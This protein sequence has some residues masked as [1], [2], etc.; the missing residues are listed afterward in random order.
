MDEKEY[1]TTKGI[2]SR[3]VLDLKTVF[4][5]SKTCSK[6]L[7]NKETE[8]M[9]RDLVIRALDVWDKIPKAAH[10]LWNDIIEAAG[11]YPY[12]KVDKLQGTALLRQE[13]HRSDFLKDKFLHSEQMGLSHILHNSEQSL[14]VSAPTSFGKSLLIEELVASKKYKNIVVIQPT[15]ALLDETRKKLQ[16]YSRE[17]NIVVATTQSFDPDRRN[18]FLFTGERVVEY[19]EFPPVDFFVVDEFYKLSMDRDDER[20]TSLNEA[21]YRLLKM[22]QR[23]YMLGPNIKSISEGFS[24]TYDA[25]WE[26]TSYATVAV[27]IE[28]L[29]ERFSDDT[30]YHTFVPLDKE[31]VSKIEVDDSLWNQLFIGSAETEIFLKKDAHKIIGALSS[32]YKSTKTKLN[33]IYKNAKEQGELFNLL[34][35]LDEPTLIYCSSPIK[36]FQVVSRFISFLKKRGVDDLKLPDPDTVIIDWINENIDKNWI[37]TRALEYSIGIHN[38]IIPR[39]LSSSIVDSFNNGKIRYLFCTSTLIEGVNTSAKNVVL[40]DRMKGQKPIDY[41]DFKNISGRTGRMNQHFVG[42]V[43]QFHKEP[44]QVEIEVDIP[45]FT[46]IN[47]PVELLVQIDPKDIRQ[48]AESK[49][50]K[51][52]ELEP[53]VQDLV[54]KN[55]GVPID[56]QLR[57]LE[58]LEQDFDSIYE[59]LNWKCVPKYQQLK[60]IAELGWVHLLQKGE[61]KGGLRSAAQ[62]ATFTLQY[63]QHKSVRALIS[64]NNNSEYWKKEIPNDDER[65][66]YIIN[67]TLQATQHWFNYKLPKLLA[68]V[69]ELQKYVCEKRG[70]EPGDY[71]AL[72]GMIENNFIPQHLAILSE[73]GIPSSAI[74][75][76]STKITQELSLED[77]VKRLKN[78]NPNDIGLLPYEARKI[79][80]LIDGYENPEF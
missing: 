40:L 68:V 79:Q 26:K 61:S 6:L 11:L 69:S 19:P 30:D 8:H 42:R 41:F 53:A 62:L 76:I 47:A 78:I 22:T 38:G 67:T 1:T 71:S 58:I 50:D 17:Y 36:T 34:L 49:L 45:L 28:K 35:T 32:E 46:Q 72:A 77:I 56:G 27:D 24:S 60:Y 15:L 74:S 70:V 31:K 51:F 64:M 9:G 75:K 52:K 65:L 5:L 14:I 16:K 33:N 21:V 4:E 13:F 48:V 7:G 66:Q 43:F 23:F 10:P 3:A 57:I 2:F 73:Y 59:S 54:R 63:C 37:M 12:T 44:K 55:K 20:A 39:H 18:L 25:H 80:S 29:F